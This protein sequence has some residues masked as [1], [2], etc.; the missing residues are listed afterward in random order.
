MSD[1]TVERLPPLGMVTIR[2]ELSKIGDAIVGET[3]CAVPAPRMSERSGERQLLWMSPDEL[4]LVCEYGEAGA[5]ADALTARFGDAFATV[6]NTSDA[7]QVFALSGQ[8]AEDAL[9]S[10]MPVDF[11]RMKAEEVRRTRMAQIPAAIWREGEGWR[12]ICFRSV[13]TY[14]EDLLRGAK[15]VGG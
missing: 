7:R 4:M 12:L 3:G 2:G 9:A 13:A 10:L 8:H 6:V 11:A 1:L 15:T 14:A 5:T